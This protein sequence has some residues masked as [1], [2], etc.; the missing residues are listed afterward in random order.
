MSTLPIPL[1]INK[2]MEFIED[3]IASLPSNP[4]AL[5]EAIPIPQIKEWEVYEWTYDEED[6]SSIADGLLSLSEVETL[7]ISEIN[8]IHREVGEDTAELASFS[9]D[10]PQD[11]I[12]PPTHGIFKLP[13]VGADT[14][15]KIKLMVSCN[16]SNKYGINAYKKGTCPHIDYIDPDRPTFL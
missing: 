6:I 14:P 13:L 1:R 3:L 15:N 16:G 2:P 9:R 8:R 7:V 11:M 5:P 10:I 4:Q 12:T